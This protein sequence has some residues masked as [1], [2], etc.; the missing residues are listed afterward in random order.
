MDDQSAK[1]L[2]ALNSEVQNGCLVMLKILGMM[3]SEIMHNGE[4]LAETKVFGLS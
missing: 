3:A 2:R 4:V 1:Q